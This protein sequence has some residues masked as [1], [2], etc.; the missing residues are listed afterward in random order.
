[1]QIKKN[2][3]VSIDY[4]LT[5]SEGTLMDSSDNHGP[6]CYIHGIGNL[7]EGLEKELDGK[8][9]GDSLQ[10]SVSPEEGYGVRD[11]NLKQV[12]E[13]EMF[14]DAPAL[15]VGMQFQA[16]TN[17][18]MQIFAVTHIE[19]DDVT[20]DGNHPL[21]GETLNFDVKILEIRDASDEELQ[22]GHVHGPGGIHHH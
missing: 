4:N 22:H 10:V 1:M 14:Q 21:A 13:K 16:Q 9:V 19:G 11:D 12:V 7:V 20:I 2:S 3:V 17:E 18:G 8:S 6:L 15:E 5:N